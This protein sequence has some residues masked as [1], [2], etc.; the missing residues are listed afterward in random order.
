MVKTAL[1]GKDAVQLQKPTP[2]VFLFVCLFCG[3]LHQMPPKKGL[4]FSPLF[5]LRRD[6]HPARPTSTHQ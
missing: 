1:M 3:L 6:R 4:L 2:T 5:M